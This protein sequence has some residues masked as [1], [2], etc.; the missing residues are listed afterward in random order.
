MGNRG[1]FS[2]QGHHSIFL[3]IMVVVIGTMFVIHLLV[4][5]FFGLMFGFNAMIPVHRNI[6][7][8]A[9]LIAQDIGVPPDTVR[10]R[11]IADEYDMQIRYESEAWSW[12]SDPELTRSETK[13]KKHHGMFGPGRAWREV[14]AI[15]NP[16]GSH[17]YLRWDFGRFANIHRELFAG[18][19]VIVTLVFFGTHYFIRRTLKPIRW[20]R[21]GVDQISGGNLD[22]RIPVKKRDELGRLT[23]AF[24]D[25]ARRIKE[26]LKARDQLLLDVSHELRSPLT[27]IKVALEFIEESKKKRRIATDIAEIEAMI[28]EILESERLIDGRGKL[29]RRSTDLVQLIDDVVEEYKDRS[30]GVV[31]VSQPQALEWPV[32]SERV[33]IVLKNILDN[34]VKH[35]RPDSRN[36]ELSITE[37][38]DTAIICIKD[39]GVGISEEQIPYLFEPFYRVDRSRSRETGGY[40]LG[41]H[42]CKRIMDAHQ[43][44]IEIQSNPTGPGITVSLFFPR[45]TGVND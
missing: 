6:D 5:G 43:G 26:M 18:L 22:V 28:T 11:I 45:E 16:D 10:A 25:M 38:R 14:T 24:N 20:L 32:D 9:E 35:S 1:P 29:E 19:L 7:N 17:F 8:Y 15:E 13:R 4:G 42:L 40:G 37:D 23:E 41:L 30:P 21:Q 36:T 27:R 34:A 44:R 33:R 39:D 3:S 12:T 31:I 2:N